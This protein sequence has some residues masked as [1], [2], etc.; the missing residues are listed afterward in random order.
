MDAQRVMT[1][2]RAR[3]VDGRGGGCRDA[4]GDRGVGGARERRDA[5]REM[6]EEERVI[7]D[8]RVGWS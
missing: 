6:E 7:I 2:E 4:G 8:A 3:G 5:R 1:D